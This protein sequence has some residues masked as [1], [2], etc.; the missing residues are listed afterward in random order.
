MV[1]AMKSVALAA[2]LT[3]VDR[4]DIKSDNIYKR[5]PDTG[6]LAKFG[7]K[8]WLRVQQIDWSTPKLLPTVANQSIDKNSER[9]PNKIQIETLL[10]CLISLPLVWHLHWKGSKHS[11]AL[12]GDS[13]CTIPIQAIN[14]AI[15][16]WIC[17][18]STSIS[19]WI[20]H[21]D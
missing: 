9:D 7:K 19:I 3:I 4:P 11:W 5:P 21:A 2:W 6:T 8:N 1:N 10:I 14:N 16:I 20:H 17:N 13:F 18:C 15:C 12:S